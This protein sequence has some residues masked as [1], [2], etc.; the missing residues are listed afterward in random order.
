MSCLFSIS[1][2]VRIAL[3]ISV[4]SLVCLSG[5]YAERPIVGYVR[6][7]CLGGVESQD[8][9]ISVQFHRPPS[10]IGR[11]S[12][13]SAI[14][15]ETT[16]A[17]QDAGFLADSFTG[18]PHYAIVTS[19][20]ARGQFFN[21]SSNSTTE[22]VI[23]TGSATLAGLA[24]GDSLMVIPHWTLNT[25]FPQATQTALHEST[26]ALPSQRQTE[27]HFFDVSS[28]G[29]ELSADSVYFVTSTGWKQVEKGYPS[30]NDVVIPPGSAMIVRHPA[31][32]AST[33][34]HAYS[35]VLQSDFAL[36]LE[37]DALVTM[38][39]TVSLARPVPVTLENLDLDS[40]FEE[41]A[42]SNPGDRKDELLVFSTTSG[43]INTLPTT[44]YF[45]TSGS[46]VLDDNNTYPNANTDEISAGA[47]MVIRK[48]P[49]GSGSSMIWLNTARY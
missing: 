46:W 48:A 7:D 10:L 19:G 1:R 45:R 47:A 32:A 49:D 27:L 41:S 37:A 2:C 15:G 18:V 14:A 39:R 16:L 13:V 31:G 30:A 25:L 22:V 12:N 33:E 8:T 6:F 21:V 40:V 29:I 20:T 24:A 35:H 17:I 38:D 3:L 28:K 44:T 34:F 4:L 43:A 26:G 36:S 9:V 23:D 5:S 42:T 11:A